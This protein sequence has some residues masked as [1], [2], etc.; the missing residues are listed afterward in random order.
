MKIKVTIGVCVKDGASTLREAIESVMSQDYPHEFMEVVFVDDG[1][2]DKTFSILNSYVPNMD[3]NVKVFHH[4][5]KGLG[6]S[7]NVIVNNAS[8]DYII[9]VDGDMILPENHVSR[10]VEFME[11]NPKIGIAKARYGMLST[12]NLIATLENAPFMI[13]DSRKENIGLKLPGTGGAIYRVK[14]IKQVGGFDN[15]LDGTG[16]DQD[17]AFRV[18]TSGWFLDQSPAV[19][20]ER[21]VKTWGGLWR[22]YFWYGYGDYDLYCKNRKIFSIY[23]MNPI[24]GYVAG[25]LHVPD[26][27]RLLGCKSVFLLPFHFAFKMMAWSSGFLKGNLDS[28]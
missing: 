12:E 8:G 14:A 1:S 4:D 26:A 25:F 18:M 15:N 3:M 23:R 28:S 6:F 7:R 22:K 21:R 19:F 2:K 17:A 27:Y 16:E 13:Y 11:R 10:Q 20:Y 9:W 5:W 24:A